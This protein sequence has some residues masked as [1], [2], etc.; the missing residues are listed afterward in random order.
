M[1]TV[2]I[3]GSAGLVGTEASK[4]LA[5]KGFRVIGIDNDMRKYFFGEEASTVKQ[6][7]QLE[8]ELVYYHHYNTD[9]RCNLRIDKIFSKYGSDVELIIHT[10]AQPSHD[11]AT[12]NI[13]TDFETN[14]MGTLVLLQAFKEYCS[15]AVF[16]HLS[17]NKVY[18][19][20]PNKLPLI[21][22]QQRWEIESDHLYAENGIDENMSI[23]H[24]THS[25]YGASKLASDIY[26][27]EY[28]RYFDLKTG[29]FR[30][31][32]ITGRNHVGT[33]L[34][35]FLSYLMKCIMMKKE[36]TILGYKGKQVRDN[37]HSQDLINALYKF[38]K[39]PRNGAVY[40]MGGGRDNSC[41]IIE[42]INLCKEITGEFLIHKYSLEN[43]TGDHK[44]YISNTNKF[45]AHFPDWKINI[46]LKSI[47]VDIYQGI[48]DAFSE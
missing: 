42:V 2:I 14:T 28:G 16:I 9:I 37:I 20:S 5:K 3:T 34:H 13:L 1:R 22:E 7:E 23:D 8:K 40:N 31:G 24:T 32:C 44:W 46:S 48:T 12:R 27:Q 43:R 18:G 17:T 41:S 19:D 35:G 26:V 29:I 10:A 6:K 11:W 39:N 15:G 38:Y 45:K 36:Y 4:F 21:E 25:F 33:E 47:L 30:C